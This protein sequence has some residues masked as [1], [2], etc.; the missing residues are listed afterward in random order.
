ML[1]SRCEMENHRPRR[2][3]M[4]EQNFTR[5]AVPGEYGGPLVIPVLIT[6]HGSAPVFDPPAPH[7]L[8]PQSVSAV[9]SFVDLEPAFEPQWLSALP[10]HGASITFINHKS[11]YQRGKRLLGSKRDRKP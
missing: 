10:G 6:H 9:G 7:Y 3:V 5:M 1:C 2:Y 11:N 8:C 4:S